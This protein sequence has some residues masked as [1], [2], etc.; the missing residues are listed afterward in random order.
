MNNRLYECK[1]E[2]HVNI[3]YCRVTEI[4]VVYRIVM[5]TNFYKVYLNK[6]IFTTIN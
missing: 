3:D 4:R 5:N 1:L 6:I 2:W